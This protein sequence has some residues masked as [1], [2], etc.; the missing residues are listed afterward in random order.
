MTDE[1]ILQEF[2]IDQEMQKRDAEL[3]RSLV[4]HCDE[5]G[6]EGHPISTQAS[7]C[8]EC[9]AEMMMPDQSGSNQAT[10]TDDDSDA[11]FMEDFGIDLSKE[12]FKPF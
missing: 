3:R 10:Y 8:P 5:C 9:G 6:Y 11:T 4:P 12:H 7:I 2:Y 1:G